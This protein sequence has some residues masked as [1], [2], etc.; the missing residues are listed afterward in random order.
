VD[1]NVVQ[2][3]YW[4]GVV[5]LFRLKLAG[6]I[7]HVLEFCVLVVGYCGL[8]PSR[9]SRPRELIRVYPITPVGLLIHIRARGIYSPMFHFIQPVFLKTKVFFGFAPSWLD[10]SIG[11]KS[12]RVLF[13]ILFCFVFRLVVSPS[14][15]LCFL[16]SSFRFERFGLIGAEGGVCRAGTLIATRIRKIEKI[17]E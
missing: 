12:I 6:A 11:N 13:L 5:L 15:L 17:F 8:I 2:N 9:P 10:H 3:Y 16:F 14:P 4:F 1:S 7:C